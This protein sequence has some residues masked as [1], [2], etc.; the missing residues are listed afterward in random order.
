MTRPCPRQQLAESGEWTPEPDQTIPLG[1]TDPFFFSSPLFAS[2]QTRRA[3]SNLRVV[4][5]ETELKR[6]VL[7]IS[8]GILRHGYL[9]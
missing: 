7:E 9:A 1:Q 2:W 3:F 6:R 8:T 5:P 4:V